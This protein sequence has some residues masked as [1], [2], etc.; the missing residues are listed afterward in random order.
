MKLLT[1]FKQQFTLNEWINAMKQGIKELFNQ[2]SFSEFAKAF[3]A[4]MPTATGQRIKGGFK[5]IKGGTSDEIFTA[6]TK[7]QKEVK[8]ERN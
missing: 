2:W 5:T 6:L 4:Y 8:G 7:L 1:E 3:F